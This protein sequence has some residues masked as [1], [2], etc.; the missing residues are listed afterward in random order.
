MNKATEGRKA[1]E[2]QVLGRNSMLA[3]SAL[4]QLRKPSSWKRKTTIG[5]K[6]RKFQ[7]E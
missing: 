1:W 6:R 5:K 7:P 4:N 3:A 2:G